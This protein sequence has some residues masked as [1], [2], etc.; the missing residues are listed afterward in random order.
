MI[1]WGSGPAFGDIDGDGDLDLFI[2]A[3]EDDP[4]YLFENREGVFVDITAS[5]GIVL[6]AENTMSG[7]FYDYDR[8]GFLDLFLTH[9]DVGRYSGQDT[10]TVWRNNGDLTFTNTSIETGIA[11]N[12]I[13][14]TTD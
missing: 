7:T 8:D 11:D 3:I 14:G 6:T 9:W 12:L 13:E 1:N 10:E 4:V 5:A 2:G